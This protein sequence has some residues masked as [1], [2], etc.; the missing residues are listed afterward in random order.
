[1][2]FLGL[3]V[4]ALPITFLPV[5]LLGLILLALGTTLPYAAIFSTAASVGREGPTGSGVAQGLIAVLASPAAIAGPPVIGL[6]LEQTSSFS[7]AFGA[8]TLTFPAV[9]VIASWRLHATLKRTKA[10]TQA[11]RKA[12]PSPSIK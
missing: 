7:F 11:D 10:S 5:A 9:A 6:L 1:M 2:A 12:L 4:L 8:I 3:G